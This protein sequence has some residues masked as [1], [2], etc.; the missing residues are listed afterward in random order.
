MRV[1]SLSRLFSSAKSLFAVNVCL[2][3][4]DRKTRDRMRKSNSRLPSI[5]IA[6][7][8]NEPARARSTSTRT[9]TYKIVLQTPLTTWE[10][11]VW[12]SMA[13]DCGV[14]I[15]ATLV[16]FVLEFAKTKQIYI[17]YRCGWSACVSCVGCT[18]S[19]LYTPCTHTH[20][21]IA[22]SFTYMVHHT[23]TRSQS[24]TLS[25]VKMGKYFSEKRKR[26]RLSP[27]PIDTDC[28]STQ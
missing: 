16:S 20:I 23:H 2:W 17:H 14:L 7:R 11:C 26:I 21:A 6:T 8:G 12:V 19:F 28:E 1:N 24:H 5:S 22:F 25:D 13:D 4:S 27:N 3:T 9:S 15:L 18:H 10:M